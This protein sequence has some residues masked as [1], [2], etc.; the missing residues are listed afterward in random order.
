VSVYDINTNT[1]LNLLKGHT[2]SI[3]S[4]TSIQNNPYDGPYVRRSS[5]PQK[6]RGPVCGAWGAHEGLFGRGLWGGAIRGL[7]GEFTIL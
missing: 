2:E 1:R 4:I 5:A 3:K 6:Y 7:C